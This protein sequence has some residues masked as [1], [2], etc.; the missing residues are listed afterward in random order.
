MHAHLKKE[1]NI[2]E[3]CLT[4][5][6]NLLLQKEAYQPLVQNPVSC[7]LRTLVSF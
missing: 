3:S 7:M 2:Y 1:T 4:S 6:L 5:M